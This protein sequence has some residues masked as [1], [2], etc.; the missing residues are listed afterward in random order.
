[1]KTTKIRRFKRAVASTLLCGGLIY[2]VSGYALN[3]SN[4]PLFLGTGV[5]PNVFFTLD[6]SGSMDWEMMFSKHWSANFYDP[7]FSN[8]TSN[9]VPTDNF[10]ASEKRWYGFALNSTET[11]YS[12]GTGT[13]TN[14]N[15]F[16]YYYSDNNI[17]PVGCQSGGNGAAI[18]SCNPW[19]LYKPKAATTSTLVTNEPISTT[20]PILWDWRIFSS[21]LN[22]LYYNPSITYEPWS[23]INTE[24]AAT[25]CPTPP[26]ACYKAVRSHPQKGATGYATPTPRDLSAKDFY[27]AVWTNDKGFLNT[28]TTPKRGSSINARPVQPATVTV[29]PIPAVSLP[30]PAPNNLVDLWDTYTLY[31]VKAG[32]TDQIDVQTFQT[33]YCPTTPPVPAGS[34]PPLLWQRCWDKPTSVS[35]ATD[36]P[37]RPGRLL[38][39]Q[40]GS[41]L[42]LTGFGVQTALGGKTI[43]E[44]KQNIANWY[45]YSRKR[46][47]VARGAIGK[48]ITTFPEFRYG[49]SVFNQFNGSWPTN[50]FVQMPVNPTPPYDTQNA[51]LISKLYGFKW[52]SNGT[53]GPLGL[54]RAGDY[55]KGSWPGTTK[56]TPA[57]PILTAAEGGKCQQNFSLFMTDGFW[58]DGSSFGKYTGMVDKDQ[59]GLSHTVADVA[60]YY[61]TE[62]LVPNWSTKSDWK[63]PR[64]TLNT[65]PDIVVAKNADGTDYA[66]M[67]P[68]MTTFTVAFGAEGYLNY[69]STKADGWPAEVTTK[70]AAN[71]LESST[72]WGNPTVDQTTPAKIDDLWHAAY[73]SRGDFFSASNPNELIQGLQSALSA[74][75]ARTGSSTALSMNSGFVTNNRTATS[76]IARFNS[77]DWTGN[78]L[79]ATINSNGTFNT[80]APLWETNKTTSEFAKQSPSSRKI[81]TRNGATGV[82]FLWDKLNTTQQGY[83]NKN[84]ITS[85][86]DGKGSARLDFIRGKGV[87]DV[88]SS[89]RLSNNFRIRQTMLGDIINS[90]PFFVDYG[91][92]SVVYVGANDGMLHT[93]DA[94]NGK[95]LF[96]YIPS[97]VFPN[98]NAL[99]D[100]GYTHRYYV[101]GSAVVKDIGTRKILIGTLRGG[102][103]SVFALDVTH[104]TSFSASDVLWEYSE[105][106]LGYT[107]SKPIIA[108]LGSQWTVILGNGYNNTEADGSVGAGTA[109]L[110]ILNLETGALLK[111]LDTGK[112]STASP[113]GLATPAVIFDPLNPSV[114]KYAYAGDLWGNLWKFD[115]STG[116][117]SASV[118]YNSSTCTVTSP[119]KPLFTA[120]SPSTGNPAQPIT[121][122]PEVDVHPLDGYLVFFGTGKY[123]ETSDNQNINQP[124]QTIYAVWDRDN[125]KISTLLPQTRGHLLQQTI[126]GVVSGSYI[127]SD[128]PIVWHSD[129]DPANPTNPSGT[130]PSDH[131]GWYVDLTATSGEKQVTNGVLVDKKIIFNTIIPSV[132]VC[133]AGGTSNTIILD[134][135][136]GGRLKTSPFAGINPVQFDVDGDGKLDDVS[137]SSKPSVVGIL[138]EPKLVENL[139]TGEQYIV[140]LGSSGQP[141]SDEVDESQQTIGRQFWRQLPQR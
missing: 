40:I 44:V 57:S 7:D 117:S 136:A 4:T 24:S 63:V 2:C 133:D 67:Y 1:M 41:T 56:P 104:P 114:V 75:S 95:E 11:S 87:L 140:S 27:Y 129:T 102:G 26:N 43:A 72:Q 30:A 77:G 78:L 58:N 94:S 61:Y 55:Y 71:N 54:S 32:A 46:Q 10:P 131:L 101:D 126:L 125:P 48:V 85:I 29:L 135:K 124:T 100:N 66:Y 50:L 62:N 9:T 34:L 79:A 103:Q 5:P 82:E 137:V 53:P 97:A 19:T 138:S 110:Y 15:L 22:T 39:D 35:H 42:T 109:V 106:D 16:S 130:P 122:R 83:L 59:D 49:I 60:Y 105:K 33:N 139:E 3:I 119:C 8:G 93:F 21:D 70:G 74:I 107:F 92:T 73:N 118:A 91:S 115:L 116:A 65:P 18:F 84:S 14:S 47:L 132:D 111:R 23:G 45:Q 80:T 69:P 51:N 112:G 38:V 108:Q 37:Y 123:I 13:T 12:K 17:Y 81:F 90:D 98:L 64:I 134:A 127:T 20:T 68:H 76:Y 113:N 36:N 120:T 52:T 6:D 31:T 88:D 96:A 121:S 86:A 28:D 128:E 141:A 25:G 99:A 89:W